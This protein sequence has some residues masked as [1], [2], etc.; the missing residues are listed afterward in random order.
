V[1]TWVRQEG[2][3]FHSTYL[4]SRVVAGCF[5]EEYLDLTDDRFISM[6]KAIEGFGGS[7]LDLEND[8]I[9]ADRLMGYFEVHIEQ[10]PVLEQ[11]NLPVGVV[12]SISGQHKVAVRL[13]GSSG[14][15]GTTPMDSRQDA[16]TGMAQLALEAE[17]YALKSKGNLVVT[18]GKLEVYPG[19]SN[20]IPSNADGPLDIRSPDPATVAEACIY[21]EKRLAHIAK[22]RR[23][24]HQWKVVQE[25]IQVETDAHFKELLTEAISKSGYEVME[26]PSGAGHDAVAFAESTAVAML[27]VR[28]KDGLSHHPDEHVDLEDIMAAIK[29]CDQF[30]DDLIAQKS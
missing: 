18:M 3:R 8:K 12:S 22:K 23:L 28:C 29:V 9:P 2:V 30:F 21:L 15:A 19:A 27:F 20:V 13:E 6:R 26:L 4:G 1:N 11:N 17:E 5:H 25:N 16:L 7:Y 24:E 10:G 14:H